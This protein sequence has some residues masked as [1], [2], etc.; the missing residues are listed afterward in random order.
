MT[1]RI[2]LL[3]LAAIA[4]LVVAPWPYLTPDAVN[5]LSIARSIAHRGELARLGQSQVFHGPGYPVMLAPVFWIADEPFLLISIINAALLAAFGWTAYRWAKLN[6]PAAAPYV[7]LLVV[8]NVVVSAN[9][10]RPLSETVFCPALFGLAIGYNRILKGQFPKS[11][12]PVLI[13]GQIGLA[14]VR[15]MGALA[16]AGFA[17]A[18]L[19][20]AVR[21]QRRWSNAIGLGALTCL[22]TAFAVIAWT[23]YDNARA[24]D[25]SNADFLAS[26]ST[27]AAIADWPLHPLSRR[28]AEGLRVRI[29][30]VG[31]VT[32]P[33]LFKSYAGPERWLDIHTL[34]FV[35][36]FALLLVGWRRVLRIGDVMAW[37]WPLYFAAHVYWPFNQ[38]AR[39]TV[40]MTPVLFVFLWRALDHWPT[41]RV[42]LFVTLIA[43]HF[44]VSF[45]FTMA[46]DAPKARAIWGHWPTLQAIAQERRISNATVSVAEDSSDLQ[47]PLQFL[48]DRPIPVLS[49]EQ[50]VLSRSDIVS[51]DDTRKTTPPWKRQVIVKHQ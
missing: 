34:I 25:F 32:L 31:Q 49:T 7:A 16:A 51:W 6:T 29:A 22:P 47:L 24:A 44:A 8:V 21:G 14:L 37:I 42:P 10:R 35:P 5:Y 40:P 17:L 12:W 36:Y 26:Q 48:L 11:H 43:L 50:I 1:W 4:I 38:S 19:S 20:Q 45:G 28:L 39:F 3:A 41:R 15:Q 18:C 33:G 27:A 13:T 2:Q 9:F 30:E 23:C 46:V